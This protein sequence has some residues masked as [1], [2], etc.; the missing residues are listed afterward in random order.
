MLGERGALLPLLCATAITL[1]S[2]GVHPA[3]RNA[4]L[5]DGYP[6]GPGSFCALNP[7][8][9]PPPSDTAKPT[10]PGPFDLQSCLDACKEGGVLLESYCRGLREPWQRRLCWSVVQGSKVACQNMCHRI[11]ECAHSTDC[12]ERDK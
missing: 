7:E 6:R 11:H 9:C 1:L 4:V 10:H 8:G 3:G 5:H 2:C 12:P